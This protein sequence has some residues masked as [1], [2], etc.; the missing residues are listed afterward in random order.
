MNMHQD[1]E[2]SLSNEQVSYI[3]M[4]LVQA[5]YVVFHCRRSIYSALN[6]ASSAISFSLSTL[7]SALKVGTTVSM[8]VFRLLI[9]T[10]GIVFVASFYLND[11][12]LPSEHVFFFPSVLVNLFG[13][14][15]FSVSYATC[16]ET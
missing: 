1:N 7:C 3:S 6:Y 9:L 8:L 12:D 15:S 14:V 2:K 10:N 11:N 5:N 4:V 13:L 16:H